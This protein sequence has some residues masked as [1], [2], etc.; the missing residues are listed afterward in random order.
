[1]QNVENYF[2]SPAAMHV[3]VL[4]H[5]DAEVRCNLLGITEEMYHDRNKAALW[6]N[7]IMTSLMHYSIIEDSNAAAIKLRILFNRMVK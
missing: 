5:T 4:L 6:Y 1:M 2:A 7:N 3:F